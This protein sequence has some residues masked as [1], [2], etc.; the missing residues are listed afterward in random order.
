LI[1]LTEEAENERM[2]LMVALQIKQP[3]RL[4]RLGVVASQGLFVN[5][6]FLAYLVSPKF[7]HRFVAYLE[8][9]AVKTY[10]T[11]LKH[12]E[13]GKIPEWTNRQAPEPAIVY[14]KLQVNIRRKNLEQK[15]FLI[16]KSRGAV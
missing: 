5:F 10:T 11:L 7:C 8:E 14:W 2:H 15:N 1:D 6:F 16:K 9:E 13:E 3:G 12:I 4:F